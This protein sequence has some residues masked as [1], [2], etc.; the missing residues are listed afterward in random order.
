M[1][2][3]FSFDRC[4]FR[5]VYSYHLPFLSVE[6]VLAG[7]AVRG[8]PELHRRLFLNNGLLVGDKPLS[9]MEQ[10]ILQGLLQGKVEKEIAATVGQKVTTTHTHVTNLYARFGVKSR[11]ALMAL[12][13]GG[14]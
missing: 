12:W 6:A 11:A 10:Q 13:L 9:T 5:C 8:I 7:A 1:S 3:E 2:G 4:S 14:K